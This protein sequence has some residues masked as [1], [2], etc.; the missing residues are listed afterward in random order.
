MS[1]AA[2]GH[3]TVDEIDRVRIGGSVVYGSLFATGLGMRASIVSRVGRDMPE[4]FLAKLEEEG[5]DT[6]RVKRSCER[7]TRFS[8]GKGSYPL[9]LSSRCDN[10]SI[11]DLSSLD[12]DIIHLGPVANEISKDVAL[13]AIK[14]SRIVI[15]DLQGILRVFDNGIKLSRGY[16]DEFLDLEVVVH[17]ND[18]EAIAATGEDVRGALKELSRH[19]PIVAITLGRR[20]ALFSFPEGTLYAEA[21]EVDAKDEVGAGDVFS[22]ALGIALF[23]GLDPEDSAKFS[24]ASATASTLYEGPCKIDRS[25]INEL[26]GSVNVTW[27]EG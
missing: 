1:Y 25:L 15:L 20:G 5:V 14:I 12:A 18:L 9:S 6:S 24:V 17:L 10:I 4:E 21:P 7:T 3:I 11:D 26:E 22:A 8:I 16:L 27:L 23:R 13:E 2:V 19:F